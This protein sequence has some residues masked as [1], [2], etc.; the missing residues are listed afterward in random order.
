[1]TPDELPVLISVQD[2]LAQTIKP[3]EA[4]F[5]ASRFR[6]GA[7]LRDLAREFL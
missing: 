5:I 2:C 3:E 4:S 1:M 6:E 7:S